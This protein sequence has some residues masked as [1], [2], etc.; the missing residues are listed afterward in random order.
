MLPTT[1]R[2]VDVT[3]V[4][5]DIGHIHL[6]QVPVEENLSGRPGER[7][8]AEQVDVEVEDG[9]S[10]AG[11]DVE[12]SAVSVLDLALASDLCGGEMA[13]AD[14][15]GIGGF[16]FFQSREMPFRNDENVRGGLRVDVFEGDDVIVFMHFFGRNFAADDAAE[17]AVGIGH[18]WLTWRKR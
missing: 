12:D 18:G 8:S 17:K 13:A 14:D 9:L 5:R 1:D 11:A 15:F 4:S 6:R 10:G 2:H 3:E 7:A 16:G